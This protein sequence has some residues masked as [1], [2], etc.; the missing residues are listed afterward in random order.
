M[1][2]TI[3]E[4]VC[5]K[6]KMT[7]E[8]FLIAYAF[9][10]VPECHE[11]IKNLIAREVLIVKDGFY[12]VTQHWSDVLDDILCDSAGISERTEES[13]M[14]L[15]EKIRDCFPKGKMKDRFGRDTP[16]YYRCN[17]SEVS[18]ALNRFFT[19]F[20][21]Y[22]DSEIID[23]TKRYVA[24]FNGNYTGMRLA[25]Y[26]IMKNSPADVNNACYFY[27]RVE[28]GCTKYVS[29]HYDGRPEDI[30]AGEIAYDHIKQLLTN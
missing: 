22:P 4:D 19:Q 21:N 28:N 3:D 30:E 17:K 25:K 18:K 26:F 11:V 6:H 16:Y 1:K 5:I 24:S 23:A 20:G 7:Y 8:E 13:L 15:A 29:Y 10:Q 27:S 2:I 14:A 9:R 12:Y